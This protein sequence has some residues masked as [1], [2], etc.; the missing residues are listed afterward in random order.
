MFSIFFKILLNFFLFFI[1][2]FV[3]FFYFFFYSFYAYFSYFFDSENLFGKFWE[4]FGFISFFNNFYFNDFFIFY[5]FLDYILPLKIF[6]LN[7]LLDLQ[8]IKNNEIELI[9]R[10]F[11]YYQ[12]FIVNNY[13]FYTNLNDIKLNRSLPYD[14]RG[15]DNNYNYSLEMYNYNFIINDFNLFNFFF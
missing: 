2:I 9:F 6:F 4:N 15:F 12:E 11:Y 3:Y 13:F 10:D 8:Y 5:F 14:L 1:Y 7:M